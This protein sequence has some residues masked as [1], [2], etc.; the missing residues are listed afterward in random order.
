M[1]VQD[2]LHAVTAAES[3][4][5]EYSQTREVRVRR[6]LSGLRTDSYFPGLTVPLRHGTSVFYKE[7]TEI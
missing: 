7:R 3:Q 1:A 5:Q 2:E 4:S 6:I